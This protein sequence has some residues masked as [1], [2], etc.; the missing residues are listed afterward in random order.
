MWTFLCGLSSL[1]SY[2]FLAFLID[3][4]AFQIEA[5]SLLPSTR[6]TAKPST[7]LPAASTKGGTHRST[8][9]SSHDHRSTVASSHDH[10]SVAEKSIAGGR[11]TV[12][13]KK[14]G[15][16]FYEPKLKPKSVKESA[17]RG[18]AEDE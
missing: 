14:H 5:A 10:R 17:T 1:F 3:S 11:S 13:T 12:G 9:A 7:I 8:A 2:L 6:N 15:T 18:A 16:L 4:S